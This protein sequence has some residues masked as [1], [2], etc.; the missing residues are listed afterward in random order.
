MK[1]KNYEIEMLDVR[2]AD[3]FIIH[4]VDE[5]DNDHVILV[6]VGN[7]SDGERIINHLK[8]HYE[9]PKIDLAILTH[10]DDD[11]YGGFFYLLEKLEE[12]SDDAIE[13]EH[14]WIHDPGKHVDVKDLKYGWQQAN[15]KAEACS[16]LEYDGYNLLR[17]IDEMKISREEPFAENKGNSLFG[18]KDYMLVVLGPTE[19]YYKTLVPQFRNGLK[20]KE[21]GKD[22]DSSVI[23]NDGKVFSQ[24]LQDAGD[25]DSKHNQSS[26]IF[27]FMPDGEKKYLF[28]GDAGEEAFNNIPESAIEYAVNVNW[29]KVAH[30]GSKYNL[31]N[32]MINAIHPEC[33]YISTEKIGN[34]LS[35]AVVN[36]LKKVGSSVY[37]THKNG[38]MLHNKIVSRRGYST[39]MPL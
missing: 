35:Q 18:D 12:K 22:E 4:I 10:P 30:H 11:H 36:A 19:Q 20:A 2:A 3:A 15:A 25:D 14:F 13:I 8:E 21:N 27:S 38:S 29:L 9:S 16:V 6:D 37:S 28:M 24:T 26:L 33:A 39:A 31:S 7:Y 32:A 1:I 34:Y 17:L 5:S 23:L